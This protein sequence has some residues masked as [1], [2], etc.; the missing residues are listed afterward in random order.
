MSRFIVPNSA[1]FH[2]IR[3]LLESN[4]FFSKPKHGRAVLS[5]HPKWTHLEPVA[6]AMIAAWGAWCRRSGWTVEVQNVTRA[7]EYAWRMR[8]FEHL[9]VGYQTVRQEHEE[10]GRF[11]PVTQVRNNDEIRGVIADLSA[12]LHLD[13]DPDSLAAVRYCVSELIRNTV[14][15]SGSSDGA[16]VCAQN[17]VD[18]SPPR[19]SIAVADC[20]IGIPEHLGAVYAKARDNDREALRLAMQPGISGVLKGMYGAP[21]NAGAGLFF[22]RA[23]AKGTGGYFLL[24][25][26]DA[27]Y[28]LRR[29]KVDLEDATLYLD[30]LGERHDFWTFRHGWRGTIAALEIGTTEISDFNEYISWI[31]QHMPRSAERKKVRFS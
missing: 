3:S 6:L 4:R 18:G 1:T 31:R 24:A 25:S 29:S 26:G 17:Y 11:V 21:D 27:C 23:I 19:V 9:G 5:F 16:F 30:P 14:E 7:A 10:A 15:H 22:T 13:E 12:L 28:R 8:L 2:T 20:G